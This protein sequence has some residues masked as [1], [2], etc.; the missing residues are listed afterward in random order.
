MPKINA[1]TSAEF[2]W[3]TRACVAILILAAKMVQ[4]HRSAL[5]VDTDTDIQSLAD[6]LIDLLPLLQTINPPGP[7]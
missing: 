3:G 1:F 6:L 2:L 7:R 5:A 4:K